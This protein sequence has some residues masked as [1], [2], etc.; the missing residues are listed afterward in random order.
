MSSMVRAT[1]GDQDH[2]LSLTATSEDGCGTALTMQKKK[3][4]RV[5]FAETT[6]VHFF[7]RDEE[8]TPPEALAKAGD[9]SGFQVNE[10]NFHQLDNSRRD[11][12][13]DEEEDGNVSDEDEDGEPALGRSFLRPMESPSPGSTFGSATSNNEQFFGP[14]S[15]SFIRP[16][17][18]SDSAVSED[19]HEVTMDSTA[20][21]MHFRSLARSEAGVDL[22]TPPGTHLFGEEKTPECTQGNSMVLTVTKKSILNSSLPVVNASGESDSSDMSLIGEHSQ[23]YDYGRLSPDLNALLAEGQHQID[24]FSLSDN[25][26]ASA[27]PRNK[28]SDYLSAKEDESCTMGPDESCKHDAAVAGIHHMPSDSVYAHAP[29]DSSVSPSNPPDSGISVDNKAL[30]SNKFSK[31]KLVGYS[32]AASTDAFEVW[33]TKN[34]TSV[35]YDSPL[36]L[37][38][39]KDISPQ[40]KSPLTGAV[41]PSPI[42]RS[43]M[44]AVSNAQKYCSTV[45]CSQKD[46]FIEKENTGSLVS[47]ASI[48][49]SISKLERLRA[50]AFSS[51]LGDGML[52]VPVISFNFTKTPPLSSNMGKVNAKQVKEKFVSAPS[53]SEDEQF[54]NIVQIEGQKRHAFRKDGNGLTALAHYEGKMHSPLISEDPKE[55]FFTSER[56]SLPAECVGEK[57]ASTTPCINFSPGKSLEKLSPSFQ[58]YLFSPGRKPRFLGG[59]TNISGDK[60]KNELLIEHRDSQDAIIT[61]QRSPK[62]QKYQGLDISKCPDET[63]SVKSK[64]MES[65][66]KWEFL[67]TEK[68]SVYGI[69]VLQ[70]FMNRMYK[71]KKYELLHH[72]LL[73]QKKSAHQNLLEKRTAELKLLLCQVVHEKAKL[74]LMRAKQEKLQEK[75]RSVCSGI[76]ECITLKFN[77]LPQLSATYAKGLQLDASL[78]TS[79]VNLNGMPEPLN[80]SDV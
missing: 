74:H 53:I 32:M 21:S 7:D 55:M 58:D 61:L 6:S 13:G 47:S 5:S 26:S 31:E 37:H 69:D 29:L 36:N 64:F 71:S 12:D 33:R 16:G 54:S 70:D 30:L 66:D 62:L 80:G 18:L 35:N 45:I 14:V 48:Q 67:P 28:K 78:L 59:S 76:Q 49:K 38:I 75:F 10:L 23:E 60:R 56:D 4:R 20:F 41:S 42:W 65:V 19:N 73:S 2:Q 43:P 72:G 22:K 44:H 52:D 17:R 15:P 77:S 25:I 46:P 63:C 11:D 57:Q 40:L 27:L 39:P 9:G 50:S 34:L 24:M 79:L 68:L 3:E 8:E 1:A 51:A